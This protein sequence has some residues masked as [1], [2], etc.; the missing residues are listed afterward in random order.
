MK[1]RK[2]CIVFYLLFIFLVLFFFLIHIFITK[3]T[4]PYPEKMFSRVFGFDPEGSFKI[5]KLSEEEQQ[6][7]P[8]TS[9]GL[10]AVVK[11][12]AS[13]AASFV[14]KMLSKRN[15]K[16]TRDDKWMTWKNKGLNV[17]LKEK[18]KILS[19]LFLFLFLF[20]FNYYY[21]DYYDY[22]YFSF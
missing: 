4:T 14:E 22:Y 16:V 3:E 1:K 6:I 12:L 9:E 5:P 17:I 21:Y 2:V 20:I 8:Y 10:G 19:F 7:S 18:V 11:E 15:G 13:A